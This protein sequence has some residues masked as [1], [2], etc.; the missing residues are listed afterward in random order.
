MSR[1]LHAATLACAAEVTEC[2]TYCSLLFCVW[3]AHTLLGQPAFLRKDFPAGDRPSRVVVGDFNGDSR[4]DLAVSNA[5]GLSILLNA[6]GGGFA[7]PIT[8]P[9]PI[10][11][12]FGPEPA[13]YTVAADFNRD[14]R[15]DLAGGVEPHL[16]RFLL[17]RGEVL[18]CL[19]TSAR[20]Y[21]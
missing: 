19:A 6:G 21:C 13:N 16:G 9:S 17:G 1:S 3:D 4:P 7:R 2:A 15:L 10:H 14:G 12:M 5:S 11:P 8:T 20:T 18:F